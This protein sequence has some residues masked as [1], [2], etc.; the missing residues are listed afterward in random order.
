MKKNKSYTGWY[1]VVVVA[2]AI[3][4]VVYYLFTQHYK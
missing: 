1:V 4:L 3:Q 2:L